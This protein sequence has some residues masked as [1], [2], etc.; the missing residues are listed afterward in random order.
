MAMSRGP[1]PRVSATMVNVSVMVGRGPLGVPR[2]GGAKREQPSP[3]IAEVAAAGS[4]SGR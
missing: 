1:C 2:Q 4:A 3:A